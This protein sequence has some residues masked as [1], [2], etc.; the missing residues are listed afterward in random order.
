MKKILI[1]IILFL[2]MALSASPT[3]GYSLAPVGVSLPSGNY[4][5]LNVA[6]IFAP[7]GEKHFADIALS[8]ELAPTHPYFE[9]VML[10][11]STPLFRLLDHPF[12]WAFSNPT[13]WAPVVSAGVQYRIG[14]EWNARIGLSPLSFQS[15]NFVYELIS[16]F[17]SYSI[18]AK[19][20][21]WGI[22]IF[23]FSYFM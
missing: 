23:R 20:W 14:N 17:A 21:G 16:P 13:M 6:F 9:G 3:V 15:V 5:G 7:A 22:Y 2:S 12:N 10:S 19:D 1:V 8:V 18:T 11:L 4:G